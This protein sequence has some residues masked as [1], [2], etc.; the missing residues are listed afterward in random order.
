M[1]NLAESYH[2]LGRH[3]E[4][5]HLYEETLALA[6]AKLSPTHPKTLLVM[7]NLAWLLSTAEDVQFRDPARAVELAANAAQLSPK[8]ADFSGTLGVAHYRTGDWQQA[9]LDL[10]RAIGL[11]SPEDSLNANES[12]FLAMARWQLGDKPGARKGFDKGIAWMDKDESRQDEL[13]RF[14]AEAA[15]LLGIREEAKP[16]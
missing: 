16:K 15:E 6:K 5:L 3:A 8:N 1:H 10:E 4:A 13:R 14:R 11:R 2:A 7:N 12:F 9:T